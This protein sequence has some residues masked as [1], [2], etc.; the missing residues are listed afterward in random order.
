MHD[1]VRACAYACSYA[2]ASGACIGIAIA[3]RTRVVVYLEHFCFFSLI[4]R[5]FIYFS[6][7]MSLQSGLMG[8]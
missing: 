3:C 4:G 2:P 6:A 8:T 7:E 5:L 1:I